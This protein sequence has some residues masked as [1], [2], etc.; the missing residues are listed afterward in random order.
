[1][2]LLSKK[3]LAA[4]VSGI[5]PKMIGLVLEKYFS[6]NP[7]L[8]FGLS[9]V[10]GILTCLAIFLIIRKIKRAS[11]FTFRKNSLELNVIPT[12]GKAP[13]SND[14]DNVEIDSKIDKMEGGEG[15]EGEEGGQAESEGRR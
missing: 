14:Q 13:K 10:A 12:N 15:E 7:A 11:V 8:N 6:L 9:F 5:S 2:V 3:D 4:P 1:M